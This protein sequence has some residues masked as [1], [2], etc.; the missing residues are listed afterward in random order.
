[1]QAVGQ[2]ERMCLRMTRIGFVS[3]ISVIPDESLKNQAFREAG[4]THISNSTW[5]AKRNQ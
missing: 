1:M 4:E 5:N 3:N 2:N